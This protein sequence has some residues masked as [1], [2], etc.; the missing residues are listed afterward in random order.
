MS[1]RYLRRLFNQHFGL[2]ITQYR[3]FNQCNFAKQLLQQTDLSVADIAF[4]AGFNSIRR[5]NDAFLKQLNI[6]PSKLRKSDKKPASTLTLTL[7]FRP[8]YNW[9]ALHD[10]LQRRLIGSLEWLS[11]TS[12]GRTFKD[13]HCQGQFTAFV[14]RKNHFKVVIDID[15]TAIY[16]K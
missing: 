4:A 10:F 11:A 16:S 7:A 8:P 2:S 14:G 15:N 13:K 9:Q 12:Y 3:L 6:A 1:S 5:F